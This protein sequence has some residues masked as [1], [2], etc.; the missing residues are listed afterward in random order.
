[1]RP[2]WYS[3][4]LVIAA[5]SQPTSAWA[6]PYAPYIN[7]AWN[8]CLG[9]GNAA[10][11]VSFACDGSRH[12]QPFRG[13]ISFIAPATCDSFVGVQMTIDLTADGTFPDPSVLPDWWHLGYGECR[14]YE[15]TFHTNANFTYPASLAGVGD[16]TCLNPWADANRTGGGYDYTS[17]TSRARIRFAFA[18]DT[19][20]HLDE[21]KHYIA[22]V[23]EMDTWQDVDIGDGYGVC[24]GC[25]QAACLVVSE[26]GVY[27]VVGT[28]PQDAFILNAAATRNFISWQGGDIGGHGCPAALPV[29]RAT[30]GSIK[31]M[32]R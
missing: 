15:R 18:R 20:T 11:D 29:R 21:G 6:E 13:V 24:A 16:A 7:V 10:Q 4:L 27:Q 32:Y 23:F 31:S 30:W 22:G 8:N 3:V 26:V 1:V 12:G 19:P 2:L 9:V 5:A 25:A 17:G 28:P 14:Y